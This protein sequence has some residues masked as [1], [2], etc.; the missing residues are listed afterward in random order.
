MRFRSVD[1]IIASKSTSEQQKTER[2]RQAESMARY[3]N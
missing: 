2:V 3:P 1:D